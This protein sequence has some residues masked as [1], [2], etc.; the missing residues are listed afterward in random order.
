M[1]GQ[2]GRIEHPPG[3]VEIAAAFGEHGPKPKLGQNAAE[4]IVIGSRFA[5][6][7][8]ALVLQSDDAMVEDAVAVDRITSG[9]GP[10][11]DVPSLQ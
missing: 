7:L 5:Q 6:G 2:V 3:P 11:A 9:I 10:F 1:F 8:Y 4:D